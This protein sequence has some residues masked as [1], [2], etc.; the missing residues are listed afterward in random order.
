LPHIADPAIQ[1]VV[2]SI[3]A[4]RN[5]LL[6]K[7]GILKKQTEVIIDKRG[8][9]TM[10]LEIEVLPAMSNVLNDIEQE[11]LAHA[12]SEHTLDKMGWKSDVAGRIKAGREHIYKAGYV[13]A[14]QNVLR[15][16]DNTEAK[17]HG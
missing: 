4:E 15:V 16:I 11:V 17:S 3:I 7:N 5:I 13:T 8:N 1:A 2:G 12:I 14:I 6:K 10:S 9:K